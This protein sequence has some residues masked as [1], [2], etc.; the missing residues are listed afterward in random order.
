MKSSDNQYYTKLLTNWTC[1]TEGSWIHLFMDCLVTQAFKI[2][3]QDQLDLFSSW[4]SPSSS[5]ISVVLWLL[6][7]LLVKVHL[8]LDRFVTSKTCFSHEIAQPFSTNGI[9][10]KVL[11]GNYTKCDLTLYKLYVILHHGPRSAPR[12]AWN[13]TSL[14]ET[15][16]R[17]EIWTA[18]KFH[19][20]LSP[21]PSHSLP[22]CSLIKSPA[23][24]H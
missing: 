10:G 14:H 19:A 1:S 24:S 2:G 8:F 16:T 11:Y 17:V 13:H 6:N 21:S 18:N 5:T 9:L 20:T 4:R 3:K 23:F 15:A 12:T 7:T 22:Y